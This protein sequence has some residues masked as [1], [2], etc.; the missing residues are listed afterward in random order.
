YVLCIPGAYVYFAVLFW[1]ANIP[2]T[3]VDLTGRPA[4]VKKYKIQHGKNEPVDSQ[5][6]WRLIKTVCFNS[7]VLNLIFIYPLYKIGE[8][9]GMSFDPEDTPAASWFLVELVVFAAVQEVMFYYSHRMLHHPSLYKR[10]H[11][12]HHEWTA[13]I[14]LVSIYATP[15]EYLVGNSTSVY[16]GPLLM[17]SHVTSA[18]LWYALSFF[19]TTVH[20]SGYHLPFTPSPQFHDYHHMRFNWN[21][22]TLG[23]LDRIHGTDAQFRKEIHSKRHR[24]STWPEPMDDIFPDDRPKEK[25]R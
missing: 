22:G 18:W 7:L 12:K 24:F 16:C 13:P 21:F 20:H 25:L 8:W 3:I 1:G 19:V 4:W 15:L 17:G 14:G 9:R 10:F 2:L 11:K 23:I 6:F 5:L